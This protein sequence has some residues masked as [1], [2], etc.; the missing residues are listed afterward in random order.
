MVKSITTYMSKDYHK[1]QLERFKDKAQKLGLK[2]V[3]NA[4]DL[5][6]EQVN[7]N[8]YWRN[9]SYYSLKGFLEDIVREFQINIF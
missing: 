4:I 6:M 5:A 2:S 8:I 1:E 3:V 7:N 9:R